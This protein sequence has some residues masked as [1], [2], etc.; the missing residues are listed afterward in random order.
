ES[1]SFEGDTSPRNP[2]F[3]ES[4]LV[5][6]YDPA[7]TQR[8][9][10]IIEINRQLHFIGSFAWQQGANIAEALRIDDRAAKLQWQALTGALEAKS[11]VL[12]LRASITEA[13]VE[14]VYRGTKIT[15]QEI[16]AIIAANGFSIEGD[17]EFLRA[18]S[19]IVIPPNQIG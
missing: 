11:G 12:D 7:H 18:G 13:A 6:I 2:E 15:R 1:S 14:I 17:Q 9:Q 4:T 10:I 19:R 5:V 3:I 16:T 8:Q